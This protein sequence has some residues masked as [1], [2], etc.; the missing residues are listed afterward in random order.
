MATAANS[1]A[2]VHHLE[3]AQLVIGALEECDTSCPPNNRVLL[4]RH[5]KECGQRTQ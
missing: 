2:R 4:Q 5:I 1:A 3:C